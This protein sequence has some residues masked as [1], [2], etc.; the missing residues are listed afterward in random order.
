MYQ[1]L[2]NNPKQHAKPSL[3]Q[4]SQQSSSQQVIFFAIHMSPNPSKH[5]GHSNNTE[6]SLLISVDLSR[7][8]SIS[9]MSKLT[10]QSKKNISLL[11]ISV[12]AILG[13]LKV[14]F[15]YIDKELYIT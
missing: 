14:E 10:S 12:A 8:G 5:S 9:A 6:P 15:G 13:S 1:S 2:L 4:Q 3:A 11:L 7:L